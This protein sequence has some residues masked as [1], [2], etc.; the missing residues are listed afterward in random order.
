MGCVGDIGQLSK[1]G[2]WVVNCSLGRKGLMFVKWIVRVKW[3]F[4]DEVK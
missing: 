2:R 3:I 1:M 4:W